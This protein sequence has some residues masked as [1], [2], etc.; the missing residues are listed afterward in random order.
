MQWTPSANATLRDVYAR[1]GIRAAR[2]AFPG[3][4]VT[5]LYHRANKIGVKRKRRWT[6]EDDRR[7]RLLWGEEPLPKIAERL[8]RT[9]VT[10]YWR[11][12]KLGLPLG[13]PQNQEYLTVA[14]RRTG[15]RPDQLRRI[16]LYAHVPIERFHSR[17]PAK[18]WPMFVVD[19]FAV[20]EAIAKWMATETVKSAARRYGTSGHSM[21]MWLRKAGVKM[22]KAAAMRPGGRGKSRHW[23]VVSA[24]VDRVMAER[25]QWLSETETLCDA[26]HRVGVT[27]Q[28]MRE[29]LLAAGIAHRRGSR[30]RREDVD[31]VVAAHRAMAGCRAWRKA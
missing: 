12:Q 5:T 14:A 16:L 19:R 1:G 26:A 10:V 15:F 30:L 9:R 23:R 17:D 6:V 22:R 18:R 21:L 11:A 31:Q 13:P 2:A 8:G 29:W 27:R 3:F 28:T 24:D 25:P 20:D 4:A 7:L